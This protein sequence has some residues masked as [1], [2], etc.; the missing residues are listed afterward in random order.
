MSD[1]E[2]GWLVES[3]A[4]VTVPFFHLASPS[5]LFQWRDLVDIQ[6]CTE[7]AKNESDEGLKDDLGCCMS[8]HGCA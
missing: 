5:D 3:V 1:G 8:T 2:C 4:C 6:R 7:Y